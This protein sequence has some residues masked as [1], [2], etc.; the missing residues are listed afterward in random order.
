MTSSFKICVQVKIVGRN[1]S[2]VEKLPDDIENMKEDIE[3]LETEPEKEACVSIETIDDNDSN[4]SVRNTSDVGSAVNDTD[5]IDENSN[6]SNEFAS[7]KKR[8]QSSKS[9]MSK[10]KKNL[11]GTSF[12]EIPGTPIVND[13]IGGVRKVPEWGKFSENICAHK[14]FEMNSN[15]PTGSY[16][17]IV[18]LT[19]MFKSGS[20]NDLTKD[21]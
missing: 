17:N 19:K 9:S 11:L 2:I 1:I 7:P 12:T 14:P 20:S 21:F 4:D 6:Q 15:T 8:K 13:S 3:T 10:N 5:E 18:K 16:Q